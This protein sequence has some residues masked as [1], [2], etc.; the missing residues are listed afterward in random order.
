MAASMRKT[1]ENWPFLDPPNTAVF[2]N[3][4]IIDREDWLLCVTHG[5]EMAHGS[6]SHPVARQ[7]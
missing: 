1:K 5:E 3:V 7:A 2:T 4:C 6:F